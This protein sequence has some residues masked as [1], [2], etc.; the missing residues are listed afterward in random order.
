MILLDQTHKATSQAPDPEQLIKLTSRL[1]AS[2]RA[3][4][5]QGR[6]AL[7]SSLSAEDMVLTDMIAR[8]GLR[9]EVFTLQT[10]RLH[11]D[12]VAMIEKTET[13][14]GLI[15]HQF[16]P[17]ATALADFVSAFG[18]NGFYESLEARKACCGVR[19]LE[20]LGRALRG[21]DA[22]I[23][24]QRRE[25]ALTRDQLEERE[26]D[27]THDLIKHN[28][29]AAWNWADILAY[30]EQFQVPLNPLH[31]RGY[32]SI[33]CDPCTRSIRPDEHARDGR[34]WWENADTK[35]CGL[36]QNNLNKEK[37]HDLL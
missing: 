15:I 9:I 3:I 2:L 37:S 36:H 19:K 18:L 25:Q 6:V 22:W 5:G 8:L 16:E 34:W 35:E 27:T 29:L 4:S 31:A 14:Y 7:A 20:P 24:G 23:T 32:V 17:E 11:P 28:P 30:A 10:G 12:T 1:E 33:G 21:Y 13:R 26:Q